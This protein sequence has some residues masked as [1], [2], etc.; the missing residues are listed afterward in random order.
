VSN[1]SN[2]AARDIPCF[3]IDDLPDRR[4]ADRAACRGANP[5]IWFCDDRGASYRE[6]RQI[7]VACPVRLECLTW[8][9]ETNTHYGMW[10][11]L[12]PWQRKHLRPHQLDLTDADLRRFDTVHAKPRFL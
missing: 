5:D 10:G 12:A 6:A 8:A 11:G 7:C 1:Q 2:N 3:R 4:W 9:V